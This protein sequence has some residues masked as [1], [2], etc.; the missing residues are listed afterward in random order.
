MFINVDFDV[1]GCVIAT[2]SENENKA[3]FFPQSIFVF[4]LL[5][6]LRFIARALDK[7]IL[8]KVNMLSDTLWLMYDERVLKEGK[9]VNNV[10]PVTKHGT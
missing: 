6:L 7:E 10:D 3:N 8:L 9:H 1:F 5:A 2:I 4:N